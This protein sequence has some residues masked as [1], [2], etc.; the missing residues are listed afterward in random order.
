MTVERARF[1]RA[2]AAARDQDSAGDI[3]Q[4]GGLRFVAR[5]APTDTV[6]EFLACILAAN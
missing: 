6:V 1:E 3:S 4:G 2:K 5:Q